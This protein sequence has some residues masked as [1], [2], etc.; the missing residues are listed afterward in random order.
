MKLRDIIYPKPKYVIDED[1]CKCTQCKN[2]RLDKQ[3]K[4]E[5]E[6]FARKLDRI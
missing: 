4:K 2:K 5:V 3:I 6:E 1:N